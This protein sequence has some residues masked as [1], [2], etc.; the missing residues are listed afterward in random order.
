MIRLFLK[1]HILKNRALILQ[2]SRYIKEFTQLL[3][4]Q[5]NT[6]VKWT[7]DEITL[8]SSQLRH[9]SLYVPALIIFVLPFGSLLLPFLAEILDR[10]EKSRAD[11]ES[12]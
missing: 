9:L 6:G 3:M 12:L 2:E 7:R 1:K 8:L 4:K 10:R 5:R 11:K